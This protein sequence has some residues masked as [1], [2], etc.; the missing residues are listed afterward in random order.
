MRVTTNQMYTQ[1]LSRILELQRSATDAQTQIATGKRVLQPADD[2]VAAAAVMQIEERVAAVAQFDRN[3][4]IAEQRLTQVDD[5]LNGVT[6]VLQRVRELVIQGRS[7]SLAFSDRKAIAAEVREQLDVLIDLG[8]TRNASGEYI[9]AGASA[10]TRPFTRDAAGVVSFNGDQLARRIQLSETRAVG[11]S[12]SGDHAF[13]KVRSGN[14]TFATGRNPANT[15][16]GQISDNIV[17]AGTAFL[18]H[19]YRIRF[20]SATTFDVIDDTAA[21]TVLAAQTYVP[22]AAIAFDGMAV[23][24]IGAPATG[25]EFTVE[26]SPYQSMFETLRNVA[27]A[28]ETPVIDDAG[29]AA[30]GFD[31]DRSIENLDMAMEKVAELRATTGAR[32]NTI[33]AQRNINADANL[34]LQVTQSSLED[35]DLASADRKSVV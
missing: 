34:N 5:T 21:A 13:L 33:D 2:P 7:E 32:L 27:V 11:E 9:F 22:G 15:G 18:G 4:V 1:S 17:T 16:T 3:G 25:D 26:P 35:V 24:V 28:L 30:F 29:D 10:T 20:T 6:N 19:D 31:I 14:G 23:T 8:N 12:F